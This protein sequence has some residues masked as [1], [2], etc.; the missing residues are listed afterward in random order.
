MTAMTFEPIG[1]R[2]R[3][4]IVYDEL[5]TLNVGDVLTYERLH[6]LLGVETRS[7]VRAPFYKAVNEWGAQRHRAMR[8]M[9]NVGYRVVDA[10]EHEAIARSYHRRSHR[11]LRRGRQVVTNADRSRLDGE[12]RLR[13]DA[14]ETTLSRHADMIRRLDLRQARAEHAIAESRAKHSATEDRIRALEETLRRHGIEP[15]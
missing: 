11:A 6:E 15:S 13:F 4:E 5:V 1:D 3:W 14:L 10:P 9:P 8:P 12:Q 7:A 2:P